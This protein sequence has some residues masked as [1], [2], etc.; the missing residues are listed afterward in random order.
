MIEC[1]V[2]EVSGVFAGAA[3]KTSG[4]LRFIAVDPRLDDLD[5][6]EW[7]SLSDIRRVAAHVL[8]TGRLPERRMPAPQEPSQ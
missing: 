2:I 7:P 4:K 1:H 5:Q 8:T 6:S 3:V